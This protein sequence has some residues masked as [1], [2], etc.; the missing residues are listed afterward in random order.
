MPKPRP[1]AGKVALITGGAGGIGKATAERFLRDGACVVLA[2]ID[3]TALAA[4]DA[5]LAG[6]HTADA[7]RSIRLDVTQGAGRRR[8]LRLRGRANMAAST[9]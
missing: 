6:R 7:V 3:E 1:L 8:R 2:D 4:A 9:S 5:E